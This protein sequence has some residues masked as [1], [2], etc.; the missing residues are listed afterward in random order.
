MFHSR[1]RLTV[2]WLATTA[3]AF[4]GSLPGRCCGRGACGQP[5]ISHPKQRGACCCTAAP[6]VS[7][8]ACEGQASRGARAAA[9]PCQCA[10]RDSGA[11]ALPPT[12]RTNLDV[13]GIPLKCLREI[14]PTPPATFDR[15]VAFLRQVERPGPDFVILHHALLI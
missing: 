15:K 10:F 2:A 1:L 5:G 6:A 7:G 8:K 4:G 3:V 9:F 14:I 12:E 13:A 11:T